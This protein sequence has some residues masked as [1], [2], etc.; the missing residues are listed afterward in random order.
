MVLVTAGTGVCHSGFN[1]GTDAII[2]LSSSSVGDLDFATAKRARRLI[3]LPEVGQGNDPGRILRDL[4]LSAQ[5]SR[6][7]DFK[8]SDSGFSTPHSP[9]RG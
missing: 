4:P 9:P 8:L 5:K 3:F 7:P 1:D 6:L 2:V